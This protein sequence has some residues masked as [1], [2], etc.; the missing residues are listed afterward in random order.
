MG[1]ETLQGGGGPEESRLSDE[2]LDEEAIQTEL[3]KLERGKYVDPET[4]FFDD[5]PTAGPGI[6]EH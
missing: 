6:I 2:E 5:L 4:A 3:E 1:R